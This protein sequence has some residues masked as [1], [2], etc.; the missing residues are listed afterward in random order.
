MAL[1]ILGFWLT[2][3]TSIGWAA[4]TDEAGIPLGVGDTVLITVY[5]EP[6]LTVSTKIG[7]NGRVKFPLIGERVV[8]GKQPEQLASEL[9]AAYFDGYLVSPS[10]SVDVKSYRPIY[11]RGAVKSP[12]AYGFELG[13]T[14]DQ[15][16]ALAG[17]LKDRAS[18]SEWKL[19]RGD[20][21]APTTVKKDSAVLPGDIIEIRESLF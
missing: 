21:P 17:G 19:F 11:I 5:N 6:D 12:G 18:N 10:V 7:Q 8:I 20:N 3:Y 16:I 1:R 15:A 9:E 4:S 13:M 14:V 2:L